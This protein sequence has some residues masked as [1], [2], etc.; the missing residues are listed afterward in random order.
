MGRISIS[1]GILLVLG[2]VLILIAYTTIGNVPIAG[3]YGQYI[4]PILG[5]MLIVLAFV[6][7]LRNRK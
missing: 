1:V 2:V 5:P 7:A 4:F 6:L 3:V